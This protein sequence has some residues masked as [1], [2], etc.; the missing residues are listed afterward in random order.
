M[1]AFDEADVCRSI[2]DTL[3]TGLCV[4]D[5]Q[6]KII[7]WSNGAERI[8]G[9]SRHDVVGH[10]CIAEPLVHCDQPGC[11]FC[12]EDCPLA[13]A[14]K[15][16]QPAEGLGFLHHKQ[17]HEIPVRIR[18]VPIHNSRG[19]I[20]GAA[21]VFEELQPPANQGRSDQLRQ[22]PEFVD[23]VTGLANHTMMQTH[24]RHALSAMAEVRVPVAV[25]CFRVEG[26][27]RFRASLGTEAAS[28]LLRVVA[29][30]LESVLWITDFVGRWSEDEFLAILGGAHEE[31]LPAVK[32]RVRRALSGEGIEW[33]GERRS[34]PVSIGEAVAQTDDS[35]ESLLER[36]H[37]SLNAAS[38]WRMGSSAIGSSTTGS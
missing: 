24:L 4:L 1:S 19:S 12:A 2:L 18:A 38:A 37:K 16:S 29:R 25:L 15:N 32:E 34:L 31:S 8:T 21:E 7:F 28:S 17:G 26:L 22:F 9:H 10:S 36:V 6:K 5:T 23:G 27:S 11:E 33:W 14:M 35:I 3:P 13:L 20:I 30:T